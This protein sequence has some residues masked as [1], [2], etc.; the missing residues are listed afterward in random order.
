MRT[1]TISMLALS[2]VLAGC[3]SPDVGQSCT[4]QVGT[5]N[6]NTEPV[7]ADYLESG[8]DNG[9]DNLVCIKSPDQPAGSAVKSNPYCSKQC[10]SNSDCFQSET[11][12]VCRQVTI[13]RNFINTLPEPQ[14]NEYYRILDCEFSAEGTLGQCPLQFESYCA[15][16]LQ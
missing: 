16:P 1:A 8:A 13:D 15:T 12:L 10:V 11:G 2:A 14:R 7:L 3:Q 5:V 9:C 4:L 6:L